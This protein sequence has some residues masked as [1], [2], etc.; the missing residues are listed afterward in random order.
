MINRK[1]FST[2]AFYIVL[3]T[4][5]TTGQCFAKNSC[6]IDGK[7]ITKLALNS[8]YKISSTKISGGGSCSVIKSSVIA[9]ANQTHNT[10]CQFDFFSNLEFKN[11]ITVRRVKFTKPYTFIKKYNGANLEFTIKVTATVGKSVANTLANI[12]L[13]GANCENWQENF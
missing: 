4:V 7:E 3:G 13:N 5:L 10:V 2:K 8:G 12:T 9:G 11:G 1:L 6:T